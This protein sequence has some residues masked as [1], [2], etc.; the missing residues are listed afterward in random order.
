MEKQKPLWIDELPYQV[1]AYIGVCP[2]CGPDQLIFLLQDSKGLY[3]H[4]MICKQD[5][6][7]S[8]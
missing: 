2:V 5:F 6:R 4:C 3:E 8:D 7:R 1:D